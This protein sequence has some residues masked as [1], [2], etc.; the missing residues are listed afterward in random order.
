[1]QA[2]WAPRPQTSARDAPQTQ[3][4]GIVST[5]AAL[6][7]T[8]HPPRQNLSATWD[9]GNMFQQS[10]GQVTG[11]RR[12]ACSEVKAGA[13]LCEETKKHQRPDAQI[14]R[15]SGGGQVGGRWGQGDKGEVITN[16]KSVVTKQSRDGEYSLG[17]S[18]QGCGN[19]ARGQGA[20][21]QLRECLLKRTGY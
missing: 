10:Q 1:M 14:H 17:D 16:C 2:T 4:R 20:C 12:T 7:R 13:H 8:R 11:P 21:N 15:T 3:S 19:R 6:D 5:G 18:Q 9:T